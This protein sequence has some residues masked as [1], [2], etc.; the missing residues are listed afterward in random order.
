MPSRLNPVLA[1]DTSSGVLPITGFNLEGMTAIAG[2][3]LLVGGGALLA[4]RTAGRRGPAK[5]KASRR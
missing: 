1:A 3:L 4:G 2:G 5:R